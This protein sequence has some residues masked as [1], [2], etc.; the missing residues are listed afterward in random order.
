MTLIGIH[1]QHFMQNDEELFPI[2]T[3]LDKKKRE[4]EIRKQKVS[5]I[6]R[7]SIQIECVRASACLCAYALIRKYIPICALMVF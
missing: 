6:S 2:S 5:Q 7:K 3:F 1:K 4:R